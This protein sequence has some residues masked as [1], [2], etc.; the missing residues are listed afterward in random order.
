MLFRF[1]SFRR[2]AFLWRN[3]TG[4][5]RSEPE[6]PAGATATV[7]YG[8]GTVSRAFDGVRRASCWHCGR[9]L[10]CLGSISCHSRRQFTRQKWDCGHLRR[11]AWSG[12]C[13][14]SACVTTYWNMKG[15]GGGG[16]PCCHWFDLVRWTVAC[17]EPGHWCLELKACSR[18]SSMEGRPSPYFEHSLCVEFNPN[19]S[20]QSATCSDE[21]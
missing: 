2:D 4:R 20:G 11:L 14:K 5:C 21:A 15:A 13:S 8:L 18:L 1:F 7:A 10:S 16:G 3:Q 6:V 17:A 9:P 19:L 12:M